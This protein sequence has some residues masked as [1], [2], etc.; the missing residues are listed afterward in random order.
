MLGEG[1]GAGSNV[2]PKGPGE[3][4]ACGVDSLERSSEGVNGS[5]AGGN[6]GADG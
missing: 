1:S 5:G 6:G 3:D 2:G 4:C